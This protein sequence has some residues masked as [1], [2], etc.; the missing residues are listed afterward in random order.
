ML[1]LLVV[2]PWA[3]SALGGSGPPEVTG[4][5]AQN[6]TKTTAKL[7]ARVDPKGAETITCE[8]RYGT[9]PESLNSTAE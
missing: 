7:S 8:F 6:V 3:S 5:E 4:E 2:L 1:A 9:A